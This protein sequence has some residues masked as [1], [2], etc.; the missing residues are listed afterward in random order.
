MMAEDPSVAE[1]LEDDQFVTGLRAANKFE[2]LESLVAVL[3]DRH[4]IPLAAVSPVLDAVLRRERDFPSGLP[5]G[6][7]APRAQ[8]DLLLAPALILGL[9]PDG[10]DFG[11]PDGAPARVVVLSIAGKAEAPPVSAATLVE[12]LQGRP[13]LVDRLGPAP[14]PL[15]AR[16][17]L[18]DALKE[19]HR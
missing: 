13:D 16:V 10:V 15:E 18:R 7:A 19:E 8:S 4:R 14:A 11:A 12:L 9:V 6:V 1:L 2:L 3:R 17:L 5:G